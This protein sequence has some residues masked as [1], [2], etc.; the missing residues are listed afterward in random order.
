MVGV[1]KLLFSSRV[2]RVCRI[3]L[4]FCLERKRKVS[5]SCLA[6]ISHRLFGQCALSVLRKA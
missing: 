3:L 5:C 4:L 1:G 6:R 2:L